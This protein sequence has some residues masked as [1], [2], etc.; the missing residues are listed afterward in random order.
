MRKYYLFVMKNEVYKIYHKNPNILYETLSN[1]YQLESYDFS[2]GISL[3]HQLC[4]PFS[5]KVLENYIQSKYKYHLIRPNILQMKSLV[6]KTFVQVGYATT[7][8]LTDTKYPELFKI[9]N[10][11]NRKIFVCNF[12]HREYFWLSKELQKV[13]KNL[14]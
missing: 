9:F 13:G 11:Y 6:E 2:Y 10:I 7:I 1:L 3:Y 8:I 5:V 14:K 4:Q 12:D